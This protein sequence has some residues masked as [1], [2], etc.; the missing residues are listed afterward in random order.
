MLL[1]GC[2]PASFSSGQWAGVNVH[3]GMLK[4][5]SCVQEHQHNVLASLQTPNSHMPSFVLPRTLVAAAALV[6]AQCPPTTI[7][8]VIDP[9]LNTT[10][11]DV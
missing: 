7:T 9:L 2:V 3:H 10:G 1:K 5:K 8:V 6:L 11:A 4:H